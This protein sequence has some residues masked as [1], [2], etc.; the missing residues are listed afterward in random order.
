VEEKNEEE[1]E[2]EVLLRKNKIYFDD[3]DPEL[4]D[5]ETPGDQE[6]RFN[7]IFIPQVISDKKITFFRVPK[8]G[9]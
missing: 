6:E 1:K 4:K 9:C 5:I 2:E 8:L 3:E 7:T